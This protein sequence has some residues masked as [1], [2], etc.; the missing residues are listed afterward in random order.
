MTVFWSRAQHL[1]TTSLMKL[2]VGERNVATNLGTISFRYFGTLTMQ[3]FGTISI[4][5]RYYFQVVLKNIILVVS[6]I[7]NVVCF[8]FW[9]TVR[10]RPM[11]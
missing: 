9:P 7:I 8:R 11:P 10:S 3:F 6:Y 1:V 4:Q 2:A 5:F